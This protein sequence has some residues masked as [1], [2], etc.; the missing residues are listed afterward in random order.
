[1]DV[2]QTLAHM[3]A[4]LAE[5]REAQV[6]AER[7]AIYWK[8]QCEK[9]HKAVHHLEDANKEYAEALDEQRAEINHLDAIIGEQRKELEGCSKMTT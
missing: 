9:L 2:N 4:Q 7:A 8:E 5:N 1:M 3:A 6:K